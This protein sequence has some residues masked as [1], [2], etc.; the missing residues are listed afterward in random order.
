MRPTQYRRA[1]L[2]RAAFAAFGAAVVTSAFLAGCGG[3]RKKHVTK[4]DMQ[5]VVDY[6]DRN[7]RATSVAPDDRKRYVASQLGAPH[8]TDGGLQYWYTT[9]LDCYYLQLGE[10]GW[11]SW[12]IGATDDCRR[13]AVAK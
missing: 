11:A 6:V 10:D 5:V 4:E 7:M 1:S 2:P 8:R 3:P 12:G 9:V 13:W